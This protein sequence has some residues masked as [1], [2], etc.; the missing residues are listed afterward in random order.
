MARATSTIRSALHYRAELAASFAANHTLFN[1]IVAF[2]FD[3]IQAHQ[4]ILALTN[5]EALTALE[6]LTHATKANPAP[7]M[8]LSH[9]T[10]AIPS[11]FR[12]AAINAALGSARSFF[13]SLKKWHTRKER[14]EARPARPGKK[15]QP[16]TERPPVPPR[17]FNQSAPFYAGLWKDRGE[18][19][20]T[21]KVWTGSCW[22][23]IKLRTLAREL[24]E[25]FELGSPQLVRH[26]KQWWLH[27]SLEKTFTAPPKGAAQISDAQT[28]IC[29]VDMNLN[30]H[31]AVCTVQTVEGTILATRFIGGGTEIAGFRKRQLGR[32]ARNR[33]KTGL[34]AE[35]EQDNA[36]L[37]RKIR[38][39]DEHIAHLVSARIVQ[40][41]ASHGASILVFEHLGHLQPEKGKYSRRGNS[42]RAY[43]MK[44][45]IFR[46][47]RYKAW[48]QKIIT[49]RV[50]PRNTS[51]QCHRCHRLVVRYQAGQPQK[52]YT[53]GASLVWC[54]TCQMRDHADRNASLRIGQRLLERYH[55]PLK[56]K[57][58]PAG[59]RSS[60][61]SKEAGVTRSQDAERRQGPSLSQARQGDGNA[62]GTAQENMLRMDEHP[63]ATPHQ[64]RL[65]FG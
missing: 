25:G 23:W 59:G 49:C 8:P 28:R 9:M 47:A 4:G 30:E 36:A 18:H 5:Q 41:A 38:H 54:E 37:W 10:P 6:R 11:M 40:F 1:R 22:S 14:Y 19:S 16:F 21:L 65:P 52:G 32:I 12:R 2:Y 26:G 45:R 31:I 15:K 20:I 57:P 42:K 39:R 56:G 29:S 7:I 53:P 17:A 63:S 51:K 50:N 33:R 46:Y 34:L 60:R 27:T 13:S 43:W 64:L 55:E 48:N 58:P 3:V 62:H 61:A 44:G 24:P 35:G